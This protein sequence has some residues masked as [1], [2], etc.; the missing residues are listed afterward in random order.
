M[1]I[2]SVHIAA[3]VRV[4]TSFIVMDGIAQVNFQPLAKKRIKSTTLFYTVALSLRQFLQ[5]LARSN[6]SKNGWKFHSFDQSSG[7]LL[8]ISNSL[9]TV[10]L[11]GFSFLQKLADVKISSNSRVCNSWWGISIICLPKLRIS[12]A[13]PFLHC[14][15]LCRSNPVLA[16]VCPKNRN[17]WNSHSLVWINL[18]PG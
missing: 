18:T 11:V 9:G 8:R 6:F 5:L 16:W 15:Y 10:R 3:F 17:G 12:S 7:L 1:W 2:R 4:D 14:L 13:V